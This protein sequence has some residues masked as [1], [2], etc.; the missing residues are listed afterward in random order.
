MRIISG[1]ILSSLFRLCL[2]NVWTQF[3]IIRGI[4]R[5]IFFRGKMILVMGRPPRKNEQKW[6]FTAMMANIVLRVT[7]LCIGV[8]SIPVK[9]LISIVGIICLMIIIMR[10]FKDF[11]VIKPLTAFRRN[12]D[13]T[14]IT[15]KVPFA[16][17]CGVIPAAGKGI[18]QADRIML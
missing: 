10:T 15:I 11:P 13:R 16:N 12:I 7:S 5:L 14:T 8:I 2:R 3:N 6:L 1:Q 17:I 18:S 4:E 9:L